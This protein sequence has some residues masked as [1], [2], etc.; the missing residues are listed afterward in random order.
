MGHFASDMKDAPETTRAYFA[1]YRNVAD[2]WANAKNGLHMAWL[3]RHYAESP[4]DF[5]ELTRIANEALRKMGND[6]EAFFKAIKGE[7]DPGAPLPLAF[8]DVMAELRIAAKLVEET[9]HDSNRKRSPDIQ[10][11]DDRRIE[12]LSMIADLFRARMDQPI[13]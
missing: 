6:L 5:A 1:R 8:A 9:K 3:V 13:P 11:Y 12:A 4:A 2:A 10:E 7:R